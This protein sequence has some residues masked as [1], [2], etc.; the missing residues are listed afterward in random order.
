[1][2]LRNEAGEKLWGAI[3]PVKG[4]TESPALIWGIQAGILATFSLDFHRTHIE[5]DNKEVYDT[6][7]LQEVI[8]LPLDLERSV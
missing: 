1:M 4:V 7:R 6:V 8:I 3:G 2:I 5:T